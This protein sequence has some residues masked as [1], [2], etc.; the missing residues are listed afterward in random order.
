[1]TDFDPFSGGTIAQTVDSTEA[2]RE[3]WLV[4]KFG[5]KLANLAYNESITLELS[6]EVDADLLRSCANSLVERHDA[7]RSTFSTDGH[8]IIINEDPVLDF[9]IQD[10]RSLSDEER[11]L[12]RTSTRENEVRQVFDLETGPLIRFRLLHLTND[13]HDLVI[14]AHHIVC[15][16]WSIGVMVE[17]LD[18]LCKTGGTPGPDMSRAPSFVDHAIADRN[19]L[20]SAETDAAELYWTDLLGEQPQELDLPSDRPRFQSMIDVDGVPTRD[21]S[22]VRIDYSLNTGLTKAAVEAA[23]KSSAGLSAMLLAIFAILLRRLSGQE[24]FV[25]GVPAAAQAYTGQFGLVGHCVQM[26]PIRIQCDGNNTVAELAKSI[27]ASLLDGFENQGLT[28]GALLQRL[29]LQRDASRIPLIPVTFNLDQS[30][31]LPHLGDYEMTVV[32]NPRIAENFELFLNITPTQD[33]LALEATFRTGLFD[34]GTINEWLESFE[35]TLANSVSQLESPID[36]I[37]NLSK[38]QRNQQLRKW[39][40]TS[41]PLEPVG[42]TILSRITSI[43]RQYPQR[44]AVQDQHESLSYQELLRR[45]DEIANGLISGG[46]PAGANIGICRSPGVDMLAGLIGIWKAQCA[47]IPLDPDYPKERLSFI[48][49][50]TGITLILGEGDSAPDF[51]AN[52]EWLTANGKTEHDNI[53][54]DREPGP[55]DVAYVIHTSGSTGQPKG[56]IIEHA[57]LNN[58]IAAMAREPGMDRDAT[59]LAVT[60]LSFDISTLELFLPLTI[61]A[62]VVLAS[63]DQNRDSFALARLLLEC[64]ANYMQ[65]TPSAW[66]ALLDSG[67]EADERLTV[68]CGGEELPLSLAQTLASKVKSLWNMYGPT[69]ATVWST[70]E[71]ISKNPTRITIGKPIDNTTALVLDEQFRILPPGAADGELFLGGDGLA[72]GYLG[73]PGLTAERFPE[74]P[75]LE[76]P[77]NRLYRTGDLAKLD[78]KGNIHFLGRKDNQVKIRGFRVELGEIESV[79]SSATNVN[80]VVAIT[81]DIAEGDSRLVAYILPEEGAEIDLQALQTLAQVKLPPQCV[82]QHIVVIDHIPQTDNGKIDRKALPDLIAT[83]SET[84]VELTTK[85]QKEVAEIWRN[86]LRINQVGAHDDFF[87]LGGHSMVAVRMLA[88]VRELFALELPLQSIFQDRNVANLAA[89]IDLLAMQKDISDNPDQRDLEVIEF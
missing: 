20:Y 61:G 16:G 21:L 5:G 7:L 13:H 15:D 50:D 63:Q 67:W 86:L 72:K 88:Q 59:M 80:T 54:I 18:A 85:T 12:Q 3:I 65:A 64:R 62:K 19:A 66:R 11:Q 76:I 6:G 51:A 37:D 33:K 84:S 46:V 9:E 53:V 26:L 57:A 60:S 68:L 34:N 43:A 82:P 8:T 24:D 10:L 73:Q 75:F 56:V 58:L 27:K 30:T 89:R 4:A 77:G 36:D 81:R 38:R 87:L 42:A 71:H 70:I 69:E 41:R 44:I 78:T 32:S 35:T 22:A 52:C 28:F 83:V 55:T 14:S 48:I 1:M 45:A 23:K 17:E 74:N 29:R 2:Q 47:Y 39:N 40:N 25:I 79:L 49:Q 31:R